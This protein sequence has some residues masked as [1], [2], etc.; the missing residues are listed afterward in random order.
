MA[1]SAVECR[2]SRGP[3]AHAVRSGLPP[4]SAPSAPTDRN[5]RRRVW[6][7]PRC[8]CRQ[9]ACWFPRPRS[10]YRCAGTLRCARRRCPETPGPPYADRPPSKVPVP[11]P[12]AVRARLAG[13]LRDKRLRWWFFQSPRC[14][15]PRS[16]SCIR[17]RSAPTLQERCRLRGK[18]SGRARRHRIPKGDGSRDN[19]GS[20]LHRPA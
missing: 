10:G 6:P 17:G 14:C 5:R 19:P 4:P 11:Q 7:G 15:P 18:A 1:P 8:A 13:S 16:P 20:R 12:Q 9:A 3:L 2:S